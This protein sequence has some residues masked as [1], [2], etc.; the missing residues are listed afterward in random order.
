M[1]TLEIGLYTMENLDKLETVLARLEA[2]IAAR[3]GA[4]PKSSYTAQGCWPI[5]PA[6]PRNSARR[7]WRR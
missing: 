3:R 2:V 4:D 6:P 5:P 7:R 1:E